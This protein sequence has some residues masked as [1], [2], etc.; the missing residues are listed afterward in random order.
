MTTLLALP[1]FVSRNNILDNN[2]L[3]TISGK[4]IRGTPEKIYLNI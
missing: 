4:R 3:T 1:A 2:D